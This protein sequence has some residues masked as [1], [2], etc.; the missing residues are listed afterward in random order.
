MP[1]ALI[2]G[3]GGQDGHYLV[4]QL[5]ADGTEVHALVHPDERPPE[6]PDVVTH[7]GDITDV[8]ATR[9]LLLDVSPDEVYNLAAMSSVAASWA[10][11]KNAEFRVNGEAAVWLMESAHLLQ[12]QRDRSVRFLQ[13]STAEIFGQPE[14]SPQDERTP[15]RPVS[16]YGTSKAFAHNMVGVYRD[17]GMHTSAVIL[18]NHESPRRPPHFVTRKITSTV[19]AIAAGRADEL[20]LGNLDARRDWG[21]APDYV[22]AMVRAARADTAA[23]Y[24]VATG[25]AHSVRDFVGAAFAAAGI[26]DWAD[27]VRVDQAFVRPVDPT[28]LV[29]DAT[30]ARER[31]GWAPTKSFEEIVA[32]MVAH[33]LAAEAVDGP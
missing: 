5:V 14:R 33:D 3:A 2:T 17:R 16:P 6:S 4:E 19:A 10:E 31:L 24:V 25:V 20:V 26:T 27:L 7:P 12:R 28:E 29:G 8:E 32:A 18:Y 23:D 9:S 13:A 1:R 21:W 15:M 22:D 30:L 11:D